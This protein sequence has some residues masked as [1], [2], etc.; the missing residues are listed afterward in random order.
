[1]CDV[2]FSLLGQEGR[3]QVNVSEMTFDREA[4][5]G[6]EGLV[7]C[8]YIHYCDQAWE[9]E[10]CQLG[11]RAPGGLWLFAETPNRKVYMITVSGEFK[12]TTLQ[13]SLSAPHL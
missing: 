13:S 3:F 4:L 9:E 12:G 10:Y 7:K 8:L 6:E 5:G 1:M 11:E 2:T